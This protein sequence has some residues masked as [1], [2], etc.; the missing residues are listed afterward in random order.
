MLRIH[1]PPA[2][3][4]AVQDYAVTVNGE[5]AELWFCRVS[6]M[7]YNTVWPGYQRPL[8]Q[9][10]IASFLSLETDEP[11]TFR[12]RAVKPFAEAVVRP[13]S[14]GIA[15]QVNGQEITFTVSRCGQYTLELDGWHNALHI[16]VNPVTDFGV[17][18]DDPKVRYYAPGVHDIGNLELEDGETL[19]VDGG[20][21][22]YG[23]VTAIG[24]KN[25]RIVGYGVIDGSREKR[26]SD[27]GLITWG[28]GMNTDFRDEETLRQ[29]LAE[30]KVLNGCVH[31]YS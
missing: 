2:G 21:V 5:N 31:L 16:F 20:A 8:E 26:T 24:K 25:V 22:L 30:K 19:F 28:L 17:K 9:T 14:K 11:V 10:E 23:S 6:A 3:E 12:V 4:I 7:P 18:K 1:Q 15:L 27:T 29:H 13:L